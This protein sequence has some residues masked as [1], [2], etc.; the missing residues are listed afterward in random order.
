MVG[1]NKE[2]NMVQHMDRWFDHQEDFPKEVV[3]EL[4]AEIRVDV[5]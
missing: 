3:I 1:I 5:K 2:K 4:R